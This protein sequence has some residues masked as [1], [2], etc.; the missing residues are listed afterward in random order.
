MSR[1]SIDAPTTLDFDDVAALRV[2]AVSG[3]VAVLS[4]GDRPRLDIS[5]LT[6][7]P[8]QVSHDAGI[9]TISYPDLTWE[10]VLGWLRTQKRSA[11]ITVMVPKDC[12]IQ[13]GVVNATAVVSGISGRTSV[14]SV[15]GNITLDGVT[16]SID[17]DTISGAVEAQGLAG[18]VG[19]KSVSGDLTLADGS[20]ERLAAKTVSGRVT[21]DVDMASDGALR[22]ATVSGEV[23]IR[24][25]ASAG[26]RIEL[27]SATGRVLSEFGGLDCSRGPGSNTLAGKI[28][29]GSGQV[30]VATVSGRVTL[31]RRDRP[32]P[33]PA[34]ETHPEGDAS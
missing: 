18:Q 2:R 21:A 27:R 13:L 1:W 16:G 19:F 28:G 17:A 14:K 6:G 26:S 11:A 23:T 9:L 32:G 22:V 12:P 29:S 31:L 10:G 3:T 20:V 7:Q 8:L 15:S 5:S 4:T 34:G 30:S 24:L 25:P 33:P